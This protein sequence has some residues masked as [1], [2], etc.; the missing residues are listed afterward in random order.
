MLSTILIIFGIITA[1]IFNVSSFGAIGDGK[2][3]NTAAVR[4]AASAVAA[5]GGGVLLFPRGDW[6]TGSFNLSSNMVVR[7]VGKII[8]IRPESPSS[9]HI[10]FPF[11]ESVPSYPGGEW[12]PAALMY[13]RD[14]TNVSINGGG[15][16]W[17]SGDVWWKW[18]GYSF[19][20]TGGLLC[21]DATDCSNTPGAICQGNTCK[22][23][24]ARGLRGRPHTIHMMNVTD[25]KM[26]N[27]TVMRSPYWTIR[28]SFCDNV[29]VD[30]IRVI[31]N[32]TAAGAPGQP[33]TAYQPANTDGIDIDSSTR[34]TIRNSLFVAHDDGIALKSGKDW[35]G[36]H[37]GRPTA[38]VLVDNCE[39][40]S[41]VGAAI[42]IGSETSG[43][44]YNI[45]V[46]NLTSKHTELG[47][48]IKTERGRGGT[49][50]GLTFD[51]VNIVDS[52]CAAV[53]LTMRYHTGIPVGNKTTTPTIR[54]VHF[55]RW[56]ATQIVGHSGF[57]APLGSRG[58]FSEDSS[59]A[60]HFGA[61]ALAL[62]EGLPE[63]WLQGVVLTDVHISGVPGSPVRGVECEDGDIVGRGVSINGESAH[64]VCGKR[65]S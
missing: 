4:A 64:I 13:G 2:T 52:A 3:N 48:S 23:P 16:V 61:D 35:W 17:G 10:D 39:S 20:N 5:A 58:N 45:T 59:L 14:L 24:T 57:C 40:S 26:E 37:I 50:E 27:I 15:I 51:T 63:S 56:N 36:R 65:G 12:E 49:I 29:L 25:L 34:V 9:A 47:V 11:V 43:G 7:V 28:L 32:D 19:N 41:F 54:D 38:H 55:R 8:G 42:A 6:V 44:I 33:A 30:S 18:Q 60:P 22:A 31:T 62:F 1:D 53:Q 21:Y 46:K